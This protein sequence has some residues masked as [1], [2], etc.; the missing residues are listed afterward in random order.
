MRRLPPLNALR[1]LEAAGRHGSFTRA[2]EE[3]HVTPGAISRQIKYIEETFG[4]TLFERRAGALVATNKCV[5]YTRALSDAFQRVENAT[6]KLLN[7]DR[8]RELNLSC[9]MT[10]A[11]RWMVPRLTSFH[12]KHPEWMMRMTAAVPPPRLID[13]GD[14]D[15]FIQLNDG[16]QTDLEYEHLITNEL[17]P[18]CSPGLLEAHAPLRSPAD[19][20]RLPLLHS[21]LRPSH[22]P[23]WLATAGVE[24][25]DA[26]AGHFHG[27]SALAYQAALQGLGAAMGQVA[28]VLDD[29]KAGRLVTPFKILVADNENFNF[30]WGPKERTRKVEEFHAWI[31]EQASAHAAEVRTVT[32]NFLRLNKAP[33]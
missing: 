6:G 30:I 7:F 10:F 20:A 11:L 18:V 1:A 2:A 9:S 21:L 29:L 25:V 31:M 26:T 5:E 17:V 4:L 32:A 3:L 33:A 19:L 14:V 24:N 23:D 22:W 28:F 13:G 15:V 12:A 27:T 8:E 16:S